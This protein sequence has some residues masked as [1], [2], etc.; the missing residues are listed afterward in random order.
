MCSK[1]SI[2]LFVYY[3]IKTFYMEIIQTID[4]DNL[5]G[6]YTNILESVCNTLY[7]FLTNQ[8]LNDILELS[9]NANMTITYKI[10]KITE[11]VKKKEKLKNLEK[12]KLIKK[13]DNL[14]VKNK[15]CDI[16]LDNYKIGEYK[17]KLHYCNHTFHRKCIDKWLHISKNMECPLCRTS[18]C[19]LQLIE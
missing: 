11:G 19:D 4:T 12:Y 10:S 1:S 6:D 18:Y 15:K 16:C 9:N 8:H 17:R 3:N 5:S 7:S 13:C 2:L 14:I